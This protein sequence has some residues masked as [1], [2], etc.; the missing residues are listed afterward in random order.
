MPDDCKL[1]LALLGVGLFAYMW[2][3]AEAPTSLGRNDYAWRF[4]LRYLPD[5]AT[6]VLLV[7]LF[8]LA[9]LWFMG[10][11]WGYQP[12]L[13]ASAIVLLALGALCMLGVASIYLDPVHRTTVVKDTGSALVRVLLT[14]LPLLGGTFLL[15]VDRMRKAGKGTRTLV[16]SPRAIGSVLLALG[17]CLLWW[18]IESLRNPKAIPVL[19]FAP[20]CLCMFAGWC[21]L[22]KKWTAR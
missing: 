17:P 20:P 14:L 8:T 15:R 9:L 1:V 22:K 7:C 18:A 12:S 5:L 10:W 4:S 13:A 3:V 21:L 19:P 6:Q 2:I 11:R 16:I